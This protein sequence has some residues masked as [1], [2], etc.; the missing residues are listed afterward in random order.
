MARLVWRTGDDQDWLVEPKP[1]GSA[2][3]VQQRAEDK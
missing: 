1:A 2:L 3:L